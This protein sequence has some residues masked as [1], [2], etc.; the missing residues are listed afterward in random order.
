[1]RGDR[2]LIGLITEFNYC[3]RPV[4]TTLPP[5]VPARARK[6]ADQIK[7]RL[8]DILRH[9]LTGLDDFRKDLYQHARSS[10][11]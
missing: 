5:L 4:P 10:R 6:V 11:S 7:V 1:M 2:T 9:R 8:Y 3:Q